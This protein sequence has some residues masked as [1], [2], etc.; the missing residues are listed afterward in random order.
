MILGTI[1]VLWGYTSYIKAINV[2]DHHHSE[3]P[4]TLSWHIKKFNEILAA[5]NFRQSLNQENRSLKLWKVVVTRVPDTL[6]K[7]GMDRSLGELYPFL[8]ILF[9]LNPRDLYT[10]GFHRVVLGCV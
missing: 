9:I 3:E 8:D 4:E 5:D 7:Y 1:N 2:L 10:L 6:P